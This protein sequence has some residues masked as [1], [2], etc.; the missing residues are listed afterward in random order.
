MSYL[1][2]GGDMI[3]VTFLKDHSG[4]MREIIENK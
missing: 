4:L 2:L 1:N 3:G